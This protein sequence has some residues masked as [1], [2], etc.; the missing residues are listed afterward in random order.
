VAAAVVVLALLSTA[1]L[2]VRGAMHD[3]RELVEQAWRAARR[4]ALVHARA[5][6]S[7]NSNELRQCSGTAR[8]A[9]ELTWELPERDGQQLELRAS[10]DELVR[11]LDS[12]D[13]HQLTSAI[14]RSSRAGSAF[15]WLAVHTRL[16]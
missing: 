8:T 15:G 14:E 3:R 13:E 12:G 6:N 4:C 2:A 7:A 9:A 1:I 16:H 5:P 11:A 10:L